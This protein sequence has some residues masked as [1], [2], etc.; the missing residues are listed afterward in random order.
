MNYSFSET[1][2]VGPGL[3]IVSNDYYKPFD[4]LLFKNQRMNEKDILHIY[5]FKRIRTIVKEYI[6]EEAETEMQ[7]ILFFVLKNDSQGS[8]SNLHRRRAMTYTYYSVK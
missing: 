5:I 8:D 7:T 6:Y 2:P 3:Y 4:P 1:I